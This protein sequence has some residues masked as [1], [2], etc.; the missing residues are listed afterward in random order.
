MC[1]VCSFRVLVRAGVLVL[2]GSL[3][4]AGLAQ[5]PRPADPLLSALWQKWDANRD[6]NVQVEE[7]SVELAKLAVGLDRDG[8][9]AISPEE[10]RQ[11]VEELPRLIGDLAAKV[12]PTRQARREALLD[13]IGN[14]SLPL[15][16]VEAALG[17]ID[18]NGDRN[19]SVAE[20][21]A[22]L[23]FVGDRIEQRLEARLVAIH[24][25]LG[26]GGCPLRR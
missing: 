24:R 22:A 19:L 26:A 3:S 20:G 17:A 6:Q 14:C 15:D 11:A 9:G 2:A 21:V 7:L 1:V 13:E 25:D 12:P 8:N 23:R 16:A 4:S 5:V 10:F 18:S